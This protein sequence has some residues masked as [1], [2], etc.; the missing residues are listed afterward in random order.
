MWTTTTAAMITTRVNMTTPIIAPI[1]SSL[2]SDLESFLGIT[3]SVT[4]PSFWSKREESGKM[5]RPL[6]EQFLRG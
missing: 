2:S 5:T 6:D 3:F 1:V 4:N